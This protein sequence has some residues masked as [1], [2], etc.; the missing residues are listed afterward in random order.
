MRQFM[1]GII[2]A[3]VLAIV[4]SA[5]AAEPSVEFFSPQGEVKVV[6][7]VNAR[8][9]EQMVPFGDPRIVEPFDISCPEKG[10]GRWADGKNWVYDLERDL[11]AGVVCTFTVKADLKTL[12]GAAIEGSRKF[13]FT[14]G[15]PSILR[16]NP[17]EGGYIDE[18]QV[19]ILALAAEARESSILSHAFCTAEGVS[20]KVGIRFI[21]GKDREELLKAQGQRSR[22]GLSREGARDFPM[23]VV[24]CKQRFPNNAKV[25]L[26]WGK[27]IESLS[28]V[29][30]SADQ[31]LTY[32]VREPFHAAFSC[33][34]EN[35]KADCIPILPLDLYFSGAIARAYA[36]KIV[37]KG[38]DNAVLKPLLSR[39]EQDGEDETQ[40]Q[41][42]VSRV[43]FPAPLP[44]LSTFTIEL[45]GE[46]KDEAGRTLANA[47]RFPLTVRTADSPPLAKFAAD[48][49]IIERADP[50]LPVTVRN[51]E[52]EAKA[53]M[54][55]AVD[56]KNAVEKAAEGVSGMAGKVAGAVKSFF[57]GEVTGN[58]RT[59]A[60][61]GDVM[62]WLDRVQSKDSPGLQILTDKNVGSKAREF[63]VPKPNGPKAFE[64][65]GIPLHDPGFY[66]VELESRILGESLLG[67]PKPYYA[68]AAAL[69]TNLAAH[70]K[71]GR[72]SSLVWVT[73]LDKAEPVKDAQVSVRD[74]EN[75]VYWE[76][77]TDERGV[78]IVAKE[79]PNESTLPRC[80]S[81][82]MRGYYVFARTADD[83]TFVRS[84]WDDGIEPWRFNLSHAEYRGP[85][86]AH[87]VLDRSLLRAGET[88]SMKHLIRKHVMAGFAPAGQLPQAVLIQHQG[89]DQRYE[90]PLTWDKNGIAESTWQIPR[91]AKLGTYS[92]TLLMKG[93]GKKKQ[94]RAVGGYEEGDEGYV[95]ADGWYSGSFRVEEFRVPL[96]KGIIQPPKDPLVNAREATVDL[97]VKYLSGGGA[98]GAAVKLR[99]QVS[100]RSV[101]FEQY[102]N[103][104]FANGAVKEGVVEQGQQR[105]YE[106]ED[107]EGEEGAPQPVGQ[108]AQKGARTEELVLDMAGAL[109]APITGLPKTEVPQ[110]V[111]AEMEFRDPNGEVQTVSQRIPLWP[112][113]LLVGIK[114]D[115]WVAAKDSFKFHVRV[116]D[117]AGKPVA[118]RSVIVDLLQRKTYSHRKRLIGGFYAYEHSTE[119]K[120]IAQVCEG[121]TDDKG[122]LICESR[123]PVSGNVIIQARTS[124]DEGNASVAHR[125][126]WIA[127]KGQWWF[128][129]SDNDRIDL[130]PE[131]KRYEPGDT[132]KFQVR[133]PFREATALVTVEREGVIETFVRTL[134]GSMP[135]IEVPVKG[136]YA[137]NVFVSALVVR[138][139]VGDVKPT[140]LVDLGR[141][142]F[143]LGIAEINVGW[144]AHELRVFVTPERGVYR[145]REKAKVKIK[146]RTRDRNNPWP[147]KD[148]ELAIAAVDEGLLQLMPNRSWK[149]LEAMMG[150]RGYEVQTST[151]QMQ[152]VGKR[153][154]GLK[155]F[156]AGGG[157]GRSVT[158]EMFDTLLLWKGRVRLND[159][160]EAVVE[161][162]LNDSL[163]SF[164]IVAVANAD[165]GLFGS[166][167]TSIRTT[168]DLMLLSGL[169]PVVREGDAFRAGFTVRN[170]SDRKM[171]IEI[172]AAVTGALFKAAPKTETLGPGEARELFWDASAPLNSES[173]AWEVTAKEKGGAASDRLKFTQK[174]VEAVQARVYQSTLMQIEKP[175]KVAVERPKD[176][177]PGKG[178]VNVAFRK[179]LSNGLGG[180]TWYMQR[181][182]Y[183]CME[184]RTSQAVAL[185]D[186]SRWKQVIADLPAHL[187]G[188]GLVKY[189]PTCRVGSD[190]LT[191]YLLSISNEAGWDIP[192]DL[193]DRMLTGLRG[194]IEGRVIRWSALPTADVSIRKMAALESLSRYAKAEPRLLGSITVEPNL[195]PTSAVVDW[196]NVLMRVPAIPENGKRLGE[197]EQILRSRLN[198]QGTTMGFSTERTDY[199]WWLM[200]SV[201]VNAVRTVLTLLDRDSW[202]EDMPRLV[203]GALG[204][205]HRGAWSTTV[206]NA[207]GVLAM[208][209][210]SKKFESVPVTGTSRATLEKDTKTVDWKNAEEG[211]GVMFGWP[212]KQADLAI[213]HGGTGRP[214]A[215]IQSIAAIPLKEPFSSGYK[216][217]KTVAP[218]EQKK[219]GIWSRGDVARVKLELESQAD[220]TWV[221][222][223]D[224]VPAGSTILG[225]G[226]G[227]DSRML[228]S[229]EKRT[230]WAWPV[231]TE[232][233]FT[234]YRAY[235][236]YVAKGPWTLEYTI[237]LNTG[238]SFELPET[239]VEALYA[240][241][242]FGESPNGKMEV[243]F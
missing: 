173:I 76:G 126:I 170:A 140:A 143:K 114:P 183:T 57:T 168:Q 192:P 90:F 156:P 105:V 198:F 53:R 81:W 42:F 233:S 101:S 58:M 32:R 196:L 141:P 215:T 31:T 158:R 14:T 36:E 146:V 4:G 67:E 94:R 228:T 211:T 162:P 20:E 210:F 194:F 205:Q 27:G 240:P 172:S 33:S 226:L 216:I 93:S 95:N 72:E 117:L 212:L 82:S 152:V 73:S 63:T 75:K 167:E 30:T 77:T 54:F 107:E 41:Q 84:N 163:T 19:F 16:S 179:K 120:R 209:K 66:V 34:R 239:R 199:F 127:D 40:K 154:Y 22:Y 11:P 208:E 24:Q 189:F 160:G 98:G 204:R 103:F 159:N 214:W 70:F 59:F 7:Q 102:E 18:E 123:S 56:A 100:P 180:V 231:F 161:V 220:M 150:R 169:P 134:S 238:G 128:D 37:M 1:A 155:A 3:G 197:A 171:E 122:L 116:A 224:P 223:D 28:G 92:I 113:K 200:V 119:T 164:T 232:R 48:F 68:T 131:Q 186:E 2:V 229:D 13:T 125:D 52:A 64:V 213:A 207:W 165:A 111:Q 109:R 187:D 29:P 243:G 137:P 149:L 242:M 142:A 181:Y 17:Y 203:R 145:I 87:T 50:L 99:T 177:L 10:S 35:D 26:L 108:E 38:P 225:T 39:S 88:V 222:V 176:A 217:K 241:E 178:G 85:V 9:S 201:D 237:R 62:I 234:A 135:V 71:R 139:R 79:L 133:M 138:G 69:V 46:I 51:I 65:V 6:R 112:S 25:Q 78:A 83:M 148:T 61:E 174:I 129:V 5:S 45:P 115:A 43:V 49:G 166:G 144:R 23:M 118:K 89:S 188:D 12:A 202:K 97:M 227:G 184:Q 136:N 21:T 104:T 60:S 106:L 218:V 157:G 47:D 147:P 86:I 191:A 219:K 96:M 55:D 124:D 185:R 195:W 175:V 44:P 132:A 110:D 15:G 221:A 235:Y 130:L 190:S 206:A 230:G 193:K 182:P 8:F 153:H 151:A 121:Q 91:D 74:C 236:E 80:R